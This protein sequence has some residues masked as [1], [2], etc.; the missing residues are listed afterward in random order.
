MAL[1]RR[2]QIHERAHISAAIEAVRV[3]GAPL[4]STDRM[5]GRDVGLQGGP[6]DDSLFHQ[7]SVQEKIAQEG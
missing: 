6:I 5:S 2:S 1:G 7:P 3:E 4:L